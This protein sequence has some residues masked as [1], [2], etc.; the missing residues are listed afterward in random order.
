MRVATTVVLLVVA[1]SV[2]GV[3]WSAWASLHGVH[4]TFFSQS[5]AGRGHV[6]PGTNGKSGSSTME[7]GGSDGGGGGGGGL[8][9][10]AATGQWAVELE[11]Y[12]PEVTVPRAGGYCSGMPRRRD[13]RGQAPLPTIRAVPRRIVIDERCLPTAENLDAGV[14]VQVDVGRGRRAVGCLPSLVIVGFQKCATAE[15]QSWLSAH[16]AMLRWQGNVDQ[17]SGAGEPDFFKLHG[18]SA[19]A[20]DRAWMDQYVREGLMLRRPSDAQTVYTFEKSP[21][22]GSGMPR[23]HVEQLHR[24]LPSVKIVAMVR[25]PAS[26]AYSGFQHSCKKGRVFQIDANIPRTSRNATR[27]N[28]RA[29]LAGRVLLANSRAEAEEGLR[30][31]FGTNSIYKE[32]ILPLAYVAT[33]TTIRSHTHHHT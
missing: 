9:V 12:S 18:D 4:N 16:P 15:L 28:L 5:R 26:R 24:L 33:P 25:E 11:L 6:S 32:Y 1:A 10:G 13:R 20:V 31:K 3:G 17:R 23:A 21:N 30:E 29:A 2:G 7:A 27:R 19:A 14:C 8:W 22:Y